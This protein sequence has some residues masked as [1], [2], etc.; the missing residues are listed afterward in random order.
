[1][2][3]Q[4]G[5]LGSG[6]GGTGEPRSEAGDYRFKLSDAGA[7][8]QCF[9]PASPRCSGA[10]PGRWEGRSAPVP[11]PASLSDVDERQPPQ[12]LQ[13]DETDG[14]GCDEPLDEG[15]EAPPCATSSAP[16]PRR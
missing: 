15:C 8:G 3:A 10:E 12:G 9:L 1:M 7:R 14:D 4:P 5:H 16:S 13:D 11:A 6:R 2:P